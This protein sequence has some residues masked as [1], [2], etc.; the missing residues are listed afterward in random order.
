MQKEED[1]LYKQSEREE[2]KNRE[3][4]ERERRIDSGDNYMKD[5]DW[6]LNRSQVGYSLLLPGCGA[7]I[8]TCWPYVCA[9]FFFYSHGSVK[10]SSGSSKHTHHGPA[11]ASIRRQDA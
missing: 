9:G 10:A 11:K 5:L 4:K 6:F 2:K 7:I 8:E 3:R 1:D